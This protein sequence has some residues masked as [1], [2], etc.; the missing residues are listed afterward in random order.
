[1]TSK[2]ALNNPIRK[3]QRCILFLILLAVCLFSKVGTLLGIA[4][5]STIV[6]SKNTWAPNLSF[7]ILRFLGTPGTCPNEAPE[8]ILTVLD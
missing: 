5:G 3:L 7:Q 6:Y 8:F 1:M 2:I 4:R